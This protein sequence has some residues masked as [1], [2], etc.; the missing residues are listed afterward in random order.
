MKNFVQA[1]SDKTQVR[2]GLHWNIVIS[3]VFR[4]RA[5]GYLQN[6]AMGR[7]F[8]G[9]FGDTVFV[10]TC[11]LF[12]NFYQS[13][14]KKRLADVIKKANKYM[15][16]CNWDLYWNV[17]LSL[18]PSV[19]TTLFCMVP[20]IEILYMLTQRCFCISESVGTVLE[21]VEFDFWLWYSENKWE[22]QSF[23]KMY[24]WIGSRRKGGHEIRPHVWDWENR[25]YS[26]DFTLWYWSAKHDSHDKNQYL[27]TKVAHRWDWI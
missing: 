17:N 10:N 18:Y 5:N 9:I 21:I 22:G 27:S 6:T 8:P 12:D 25:F 2:L 20:R 19:K 1:W 14:E 4:G 24:Y 3:G 11:P 7:D 15:Y 16:W 26:I 13:F 23:S